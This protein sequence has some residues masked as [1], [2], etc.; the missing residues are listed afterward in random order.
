MM[1]SPGLR[2]DGHRAVLQLQHPYFGTVDRQHDD[3]QLLSLVLELHQ[4]Q[5]TLDFGKV[6]LVT[7]QG[8]SMLVGLHKRLEAEGRRLVIT[9]LLPQVYDVFS[10]THL[11]TLLDVRLQEAAA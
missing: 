7:S 11:N 1:S 6:K 3:E 8:L 10:I 5:L 2:V 9:N 4:E